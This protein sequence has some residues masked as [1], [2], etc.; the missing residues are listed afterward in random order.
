MCGIC[1]I[2]AFVLLMFSDSLFTMSHSLFVVSSPLR[3][4]ASCSLVNLFVV[5]TR[6]VPSA[7]MIHLKTLLEDIMSLV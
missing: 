7:Y 4:V 2:I 3:P 5:V 1:N 6:A